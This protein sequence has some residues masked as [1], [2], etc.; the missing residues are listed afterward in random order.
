MDF[1]I[2]ANAWSAG[3]DNPTSKHRI[4]IEL[5]RQ[6]H[7]VLWIEGSGMRTPSVGS[8]SDRLRMLRKILASLHGARREETIDRRPQTSDPKKATLTPSLSPEGRGGSAAS[9][10]FRGEDRGEGVSLWVL[11]PFFVP[12][13]KFKA[14]RLLN[15]L[16]C[17]LSMRFWGWRLRFHDPVLINYVPV[18]AEAM[19]CR[20]RRQTAS[21]CGGD[22]RPQTTDLNTGSAPLKSAVCGLR[23]AVCDTP[24]A[25]RVVY[26]CVD[27]WDAFAMYD[28][29]LMGEMD[30]RCCRYADLV[31]ASAGELY[32]RCKAINPNTVLISHGVDWEHFRRA[33]PEMQTADCRPETTDLRK[34]TLTPTL[35]PKGRGGSASPSP[36]RGEGRGEGDRS[37]ENNQSTAKKNKS[38]VCSLQ[39]VVSPRTI[40]FFGLLSEWVDQD[41]ILRLAREFSGILPLPSGEPPTPVGY[42]A[43]R[44]VGVRVSSPCA[45]IILIGKADVDVSRLQGIPNIQLLG[46]RPFSELPA[47]IAGFTVGIIPFVVNDLTRSVNPIKLR[48][49]LSAG[50]PVVSTALPEVARYAGDQTTDRRPQTIDRREETLTPTLSPEGRGRSAPPSPLRGEGRGE[51]ERAEEKLN[52]STAQNF[53]SAV[54]GRWSMVSSQVSSHVSPPAVQVAHNHDE[55]V[56]MVRRVLERP[57]SPEERRAVSDSM[58]SETW[59]AKVGEILE[60]ITNDEGVCR[61]DSA[62]HMK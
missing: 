51:G 38:A 14:I 53:K 11:S 52:Q 27:R 32:E 36:F 34:E 58:A 42:V 15:G 2:I 24:R 40:G 61:A 44:R 20:R 19:R 35:S 41:L 39:S 7:R 1:F 4:A 12:V 55:F 18:L 30:R 49:M 31:I 5:V 47:H 3:R 29:V 48:E 28:S 60:L 21:A 54:D 9:S 50:C 46:P 17:R 13:P 43:P 33:A 26:H 62:K 22:H 59:T 37:G 10:P 6:G 45:Q 57:F 23:S 25:P 56:A 8:S 16:I